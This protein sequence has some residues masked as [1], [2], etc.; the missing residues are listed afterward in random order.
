MTIAVVTK[1]GDGI[2]LGAD[3]AATL[4]LNGGVENVF[5]NAEK[6][7]NLRKG[8]PI[9]AVTYGLGGMDG[10]SISS[11]AKDLRAELTDP[12]PLQLKTGWSVK[13]VAT[14]VREFFYE[15]HYT[16]QFGAPL[17]AADP[18]QRSG[19]GMMIAGISDG[20]QKAEVW[21]FEIDGRGNCPDIH[22]VASETVSGQ[23]WAQGQPEAVWRLF[24]GWSPRVFDALVQSG[25]SAADVTAFLDSIP[26]E[27]LIHPA[28]PIQ[29]AIDL[30]SFMIETTCNFVRFTPGAPT[31]A[32]PIDIAAITVHEGFRWV[33]RKHYYSAELNQWLPP[34]PDRDDPKAREA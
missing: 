32:P 8:F 19:M 2:I 28:M 26:M 31:V 18:E 11:L 5:F 12:G 25:I 23:V 6:V 30:T 33:R 14:R 34:A 24:R 29:D 20:H 16:A 13:D 15:R 4:G 1:V 21:G 22:Q 27:P 10:R 9:G 3:S 7:F 17:T